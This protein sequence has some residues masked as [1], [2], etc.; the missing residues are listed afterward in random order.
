MGV[1]LHTQASQSLSQPVRDVSDTVLTS[2]WISKLHLQLQ[3]EGPGLRAETRA[4]HSTQMG[5]NHPLSSL[6]MWCQWGKPKLLS[7]HGG[8]LYSKPLR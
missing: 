7:H 6:E 2:L 5:H 1:Q 4:W 8:H 3:P